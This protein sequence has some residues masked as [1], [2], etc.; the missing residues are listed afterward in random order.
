MDEAIDDGP[1]RYGF[2]IIPAFGHTEGSVFI[3]HEPS[4][5]LFTGD[6]VLTGPPPSRKIIRLSLAIP[7]FSIDAE[8][9]HARALALL[10]SPLTIEHLASGHGPYLG[11]DTRGYIAD[12]VARIQS[13]HDLVD[14]PGEPA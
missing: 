12:L 7:A 9:C 11:G 1:W 4:K 8:A 3:Y 5:T 14:S 6:A 2:R 10:Q 13:S